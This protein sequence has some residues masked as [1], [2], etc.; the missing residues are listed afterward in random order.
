MEE[1]IIK[2]LNEGTT[3]QVE[4]GKNFLSNPKF[5]G[6]KK[7]VPLTT[8]WHGRRFV[9]FQKRNNNYLIFK[10]GWHKY[11]RIE[12]QG[13]SY[14]GKVNI[15][16]SKEDFVNAKLFTILKSIKKEEFWMWMSKWKEPAEIMEEMKTWKI[17]EKESAIK[18]LSQ[19]QNVAS[20][21]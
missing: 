21:Q 6:L 9:I 7:E 11:S 4:L 12:I 19:Y 5:I 20:I 1:V 14:L 13:S 16:F 3:I 15:K 17:S 2:A 8:Y 18:E 10:T